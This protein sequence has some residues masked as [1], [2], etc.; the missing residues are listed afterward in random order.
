M[1]SKDKLSFLYLILIEHNDICNLSNQ[2]Q[3]PNDKPVHLA[4]KEDPWNRLNVTCTLA[5]SRRE[6]YHM[7]PKAPR[8]SLDFILKSKYDHHDEFLRAKNETL[9]QP[10]TAG[11][12]HG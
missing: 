7:D 4:Q 5:S 9:T 8:D 6:I 12:S 3:I 10:E 1:F 11:D 2:Q